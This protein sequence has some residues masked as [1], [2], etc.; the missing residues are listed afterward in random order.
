ML[1]LAF[2]NLR[3]CFSFI[4]TAFCPTSVSSSNSLNFM[5]FLQILTLYM[6][7]GSVNSEHAYPPRA[8][9]NSS[10]NG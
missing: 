10:R 5:G 9:V 3:Y 1:Q 6:L 8:F 4:L 7:Y 2:C